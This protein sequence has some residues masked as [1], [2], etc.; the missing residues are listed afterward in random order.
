[1]ASN[2]IC[3]ICHIRPATHTVRLRRGGEEETLQVCDID[4]RRL[5]GSRV[6]PFDSLFSSGMMDDFLK[7]SD[8]EGLSSRLGSPLPRHREAF[9]I[10]SYFSDRTKE[11][12]QEAG[13][14][15]VRAG[16]DEVDTEHMLQAVLTSDVVKKI[17]QQVKVNPDELLRY[18]QEHS[19]KGSK[20]FEGEEVELS[21]S[22][23]LKNVLQNSFQTARSMGHGYVGPEHL[24]I[25][26]ADDEDGLAGEILQKDGL[27]PES[28]MQQTVRVVGEG[29]KEGRVEAPS[30]TPELDKYSR[31]LSQLAQDGK[32]DP[33]IGRAT[34]IETTI[35][36]LARRTK[37]NPVLIGEPGVGKTAIVEGLAQRIESKDVPEVL[38]GK[39]VVEVTI[40]SIVAGSKYRGEVEERLQKLT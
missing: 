24:L 11:L 30:N 17:L 34:E 7:P 5:Q 9:D 6:S 39:R 37:N 23:R 32:L 29:A 8:L 3:D 19:P 35:E 2:E 20:K 14:V 10:E 18:T 36:I 22:P 27:T 26:L 16:R 33:V 31:N 15:A 13:A 12:I 38:L 25:A 21:I 4:L 40:N 28:L 1:M